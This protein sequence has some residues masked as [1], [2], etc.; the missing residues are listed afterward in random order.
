M[1]RD[2][3]PL[4]DLRLSDKDAN[5]KKTMNTHLHVLEAYTNLYRH[6]PDAHL[7]TQIR[8]LLAVFQTHLLHPDT[9]HLHLFLDEH[10]QPKSTAVS[11]GHDI[12]AAWL[13]LE[14]AGVL[15]DEDAIA[16]FR[17]VAVDMAASAAT[18]LDASGGLNYEYDPAHQHWNREKHW[19]V[20]AEA[21]VGFL[22]AYQL[23]GQRQ[24]YEQFA[25]VWEF[26]Q[27]R[28]LD[29]ARGEWHWGVTEAG[30][31]MAGEDKAG[32]WKCPYHNSRAC[33]EILGRLSHLP[34][35]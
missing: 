7:Q 22:N 30:T 9:R 29:Y 17:Q 12:E 21:M 24:F 4:T 27:R 3:A 11:F 33:L 16:Q 23:S 14:A 15:G 13:L 19:W 34:E 25:G 8:E 5:E 6:W 20:Q 10:W 1:A 31:R 26:T 18:G 32:F 2:W 35:A 28:L